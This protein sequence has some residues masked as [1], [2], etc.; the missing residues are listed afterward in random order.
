M[1]KAIFA[2]LLISLLQAS[3]YAQEGEESFGE[4]AQT[5]FLGTIKKSSSKFA[6]PPKAVKKGFI[7]EFDE[8]NDEEEE[9]V[10]E[11][12]A[13]DRDGKKG[14]A[15]GRA[16][17]GAS[18][19]SNGNGGLSFFQNQLKQQRSERDKSKNKRYHQILD[20]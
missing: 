19:G 3:S 2:I 13:R 14:S 17:S 5:N 20:F 4:E 18:A 1:N 9:V 12:R 15:K 11:I 16:L 6:P 8:E 7:Y 10:K